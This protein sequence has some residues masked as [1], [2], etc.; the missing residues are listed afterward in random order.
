MKNKAHIALFLIVVL[1]FSSLTAFATP[2]STLKTQL[3]SKYMILVNRDNKVNS[4]YVPSDLITYGSTGLKLEKTCAAALTQMIDACYAAVGGEKLWMYSGYRTY[5]TQYNKYYGKINQYVSQGYSQSKAKELTDRY[6]APPGGSEHHTGLA[7]D[8]CSPSVVN[9][10]GQLH[11]SFGTTAQGKWL[12]QNAH[13]YGFILRYDQGKESITGYNYEP[14]HFRYLGKEHAQKVYASGLTY[15]EY[16]NKLH[17]TVSKLK[18]AP[19]IAINGQKISFSAPSGTEIRYTNN[20]QPP[21]LTSAKYNSTLSGKNVTYKAIACYNGYTSPI[22]TVTVTAYG[23]VFKDISVKDWFYR[24]VSNAVHQKLF[25]GMGDHTFAP[26]GTMT[27]AMLVQVLANVSGVD[28]S[29]YNGK[30]NYKDVKKSRWYAPAIQW[31]SEQGYVSG[32]GNNL[33]APEA[34]VTREQVCTMIYNHSGDN[35]NNPRPN[36]K[37]SGIISKWAYKGVAYCAARQIVSG[38]PDGTFQPQ[39]KATRAEVARIALSYVA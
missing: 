15:E 3:T 33:F 2:V 32:M 14:W 18:K 10:Y 4:D 19:N 1:L 7:A 16:Y 28:L 5:Q 20:A 35:D 30:T 24:S 13:K 31:A 11:E 36:F 38:Y 22:A 27:R 9:R 12:R 37:D 6:Y 21:T 34:A 29:K 39:K 8:I 26:N 25:S 17:T 23:D